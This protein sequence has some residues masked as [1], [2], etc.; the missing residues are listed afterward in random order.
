[1]NKKI[2]SKLIFDDEGGVTLQLGGKWAHHFDDIKQAAK[3]YH[4]YLQEGNTEGWE[5]HEPDNLKSFW[6]D[7][8]I[9]NRGVIIYNHDEIMKEIDS[10]FSSSWGT[11]D[12]F[13]LA[14]IEL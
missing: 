4:L 1:M 2:K 10:E 8:D 11:V 7:D 6:T 3:D 14:F 13:C 5:G 9:K 12:K